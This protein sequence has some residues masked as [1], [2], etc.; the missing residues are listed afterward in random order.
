[1]ESDVPPGTPPVDA[2]DIENH[3]K[4]S[5]LFCSYY[6]SPKEASIVSQKLAFC[7]QPLHL[8]MHYYGAN[9]IMLGSFLERYCFRTSYICKWC[10]LPMIDHVK[11]YVHS[12]GCVQVYLTEEPKRLPPNTIFVATHCDLCQEGSPPVPLSMDSKCLSLAK[13]LEQRFHCHPYRRRLINVDAPLPE[14]TKSV[15]GCAGCTHSLN[16]ELVHSFSLNGIVA[17]FQY[18]AIQTWEIRLPDLVCGLVDTDRLVCDN[19]K[20]LQEEVKL[21]SQNGYEVFAKILDRLAQFS[22]ETENA[23]IAGLKG[24]L[25][26]D[27][28][29]FKSRVEVVHTVLTDAK[30]TRVNEVED[31]MILAK[32][33]LAESVEAWG[34]RLHEAAQQYKLMLKNESAAAETQPEEEE[35]EKEERDREK[36]GGKSDSDDGV[37]DTSGNASHV[38]K[39]ARITST[40]SN[41]SGSSLA[42]QHKKG[43]EEKKTVKSIWNQFVSSGTT[44][45][46]QS[47]IPANEHHTLPLGIFPVTVNDQDLSSIVA[48]TLISFEY[49]KALELMGS[50][51]AA[52]NSPHVKRKSQEG[53]GAGEGDDERDGRGGGGGEEKKNKSHCHAEVHCHDST[54]NVTCKIYFAREFEAMRRICLRATSDANDEDEEVV[55]GK[56]RTGASSNNNN[57]NNLSPKLQLLL[58]RVDSK[59]KLS[60]ESWRAPDAE[61]IRKEFARSLSRSVP[62]DAKG[63]KSGSRFSKT[64]DKRFI[65]KE[66]SKTDVAIFENFAPNYFEYINESLK[67][68]QPTLLAKIFGV[69]KVTIK[70]KDR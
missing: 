42:V 52:N 69:F 26:S 59:G 6:N 37:L 51:L 43:P 31:A 23:V 13:Y 53:S 70:K 68:D 12:M 17:N 24:A 64:M 15:S 36:G 67:A 62:W 49:R 66:M 5:L 63:G 45:L 27:Q 39:S 34:P 21:L 50:D 14:A 40:G 46:L 19:T 29:M 3:Q 32:R 33:A 7:A 8:D 20:A 47:P 41:S 2:L 4:L 55:A 1:M 65:L 54:V 11:R 25:T 44:T 28:L 10:N 18:S 35:K 16:K 60:L 48:H 38:E 30:G 22:T 56:R 57:N 61:E 58:E 9:D